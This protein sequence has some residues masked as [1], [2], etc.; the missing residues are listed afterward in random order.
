MSEESIES[1]LTALNQARLGRIAE[2]KKLRDSIIIHRDFEMFEE[3]FEAAHAS[4][5]K[6][7]EKINERTTNESAGGPS[8][9]A[10]DG[11]ERGEAGDD[12]GGHEA[13][14]G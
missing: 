10:A 13:D 14:I 1:I 5:R 3:A 2:R 8:S 12:A 7:W 11:A 9:Q 6:R 4:A